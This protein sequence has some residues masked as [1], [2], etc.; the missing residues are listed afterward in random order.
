MELTLIS[1]VVISSLLV[2]DNVVVPLAT[3]SAVPLV[4][5]SQFCHYKDIPIS[6]MIH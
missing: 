1:L 5:G 4:A 6:H 3:S 2:V